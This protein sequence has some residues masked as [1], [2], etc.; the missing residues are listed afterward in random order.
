MTDVIQHVVR[1]SLSGSMGKV[2]NQELVTTLYEPCLSPVTH[3]LE[4]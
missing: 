3:K 4:K 1:Y 2:V